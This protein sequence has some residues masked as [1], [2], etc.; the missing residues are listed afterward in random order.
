MENKIFEKSSFLDVFSC[1]F[2]FLI[3]VEDFLKP[4][5]FR[6]GFSIFLTYENEGKEEKEKYF[7]SQ[8]EEN[9]PFMFVSKEISSSKTK[10]LLKLE[11]FGEQAIYSNAQVTYFDV[12]SGCLNAALKKEF[13]A[14]AS[15]DEIFFAETQKKV[16]NVRRIYSLFKIFKILNKKNV[17][18]E[19][20]KKISV[21]SSLVDPLILEDVKRF[22]EIF[23]FQ[24]QVKSFEEGEAFDAFRSLLKRR[25]KKG[26][27]KTAV[28]LTRKE[29]VAAE[30]ISKNSY[31]GS[32]LILKTLGVQE[33][34]KTQERLKLEKWGDFL[35]A[36]KPFVSLKDLKKISLW[37]SF[38]LDFYLSCDLLSDWE[39][40]KILWD[41]SQD[42]FYVK[43]LRR[44]LAVAFSCE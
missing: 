32:W 21:S 23:Q 5:N 42:D 11:V 13:I 9:L 8:T 16:L 19:L 44:L 40:E 7:L 41:E 43:S 25:E 29:N 18:Y 26:D 35:V 2:V 28:F 1:A 31:Q 4:T 6:R 20:A 39:I 15:W 14:L 10:K 22:L 12:Y 30:E 3:K 38:Q 24:S 33:E 17:C 36:T 27:K 37:K 34:K